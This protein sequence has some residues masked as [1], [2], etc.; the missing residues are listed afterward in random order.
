MGSMISMIY[1]TRIGLASDITTLDTREGSGGAG[2]RSKTSDSERRR[3]TH[4]DLES[5]LPLSWSTKAS[6]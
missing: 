2:W 5:T 4:L 3:M 1:K 6:I